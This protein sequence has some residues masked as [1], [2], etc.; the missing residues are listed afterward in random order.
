[1]VTNPD[2][3]SIQQGL[4]SVN[5]RE[6]VFPFGNSRTRYIV[7]IVVSIV[8]GNFMI[9][10]IIVTIAS[11]NIIII[12]VYCSFFK[13]LSVCFLLSSLSASSQDWLSLTYTLILS[14][15]YCGSWSILRLYFCKAQCCAQVNLTQ[16]PPVPNITF[17]LHSAEK[18]CVY[19]A[20]LLVSLLSRW[21]TGGKF[22]SP[23]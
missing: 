5:R 7:I 22:L 12:N 21:K 8:T 3:N 4:T 17:S 6:P 18:N 11:T 9:V 2:I 13:V 16:P 19:K 23:Y 14:R 15:T 1:M 20:W 10:V